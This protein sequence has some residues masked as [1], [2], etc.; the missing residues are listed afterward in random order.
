MVR[1]ERYPVVR[2]VNP[3]FDGTDSLAAVEDMVNKAAGMADYDQAR[4]L[5]LEYG[6]VRSAIESLK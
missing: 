3:V 2:S 1:E 4:N 6:S 5:L